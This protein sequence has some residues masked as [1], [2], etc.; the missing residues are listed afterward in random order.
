MHEHDHL[1]P[2]RMDGSGDFRKK[3]SSFMQKKQKQQGYAKWAKV[4]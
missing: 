2:W 4:V 3:N 1:T